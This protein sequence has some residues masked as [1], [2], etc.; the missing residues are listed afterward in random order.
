MVKFGPS[1]QII[2]RDI[3]TSSKGV[4]PVQSL[5]GQSSTTISNLWD[6]NLSNALIVGVTTEEYNVQLSK[7]SPKLFDQN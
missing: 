7:E 6:V 4:P 3:N 1:G 5:I 2:S